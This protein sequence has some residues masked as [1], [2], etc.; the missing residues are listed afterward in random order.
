MFI[1]APLL[2]VGSVLAGLLVSSWVNAPSGP[3]IVVVAGMLFIA[4]WGRMAR[5]ARH[6][7]G[8]G[9]RT[10]RGSP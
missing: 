9:G 4:A 3:A 7:L 5:R 6:R 10:T 2:G 8:N 1:L